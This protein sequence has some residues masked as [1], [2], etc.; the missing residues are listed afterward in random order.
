M[1]EFKQL[2]PH[3]KMFVLQQVA[4]KLERIAA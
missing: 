1:P 2:P 3:R 4:Q